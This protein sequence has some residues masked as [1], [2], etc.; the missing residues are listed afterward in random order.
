MARYLVLL[1]LLCSASVNAID[2]ELVVDDCGPLAR[3]ELGVVFSPKPRKQ[4]WYY[5]AKGDAT[6]VC[7][8]LMD[9]VR[10]VGYEEDYCKNHNPIHPKE[11]EYLKV[12]IIKEY[13]NE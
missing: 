3:G 7:P 8:K 4:G 10:I 11:C 6:D 13:I 5:F 2:I 9:A 12:F 1:I